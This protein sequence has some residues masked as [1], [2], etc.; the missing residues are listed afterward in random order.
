MGADLHPA[1]ARHAFDY[2]RSVL[3][4]RL[5][6]HNYGLAIGEKSRTEAR[7]HPMGRGWKRLIAG[8]NGE[9]P[10]FLGAVRS[11]KAKKRIDA[12]AAALNYSP[13]RR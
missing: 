11:S 12:A 7:R 5:G 1:L 10:P 13:K 4:E 3:G 8:R 9:G 6:R 2:F